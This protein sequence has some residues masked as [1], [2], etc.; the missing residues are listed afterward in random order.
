MT[1][2]SIG[3]RGARP[4]REGFYSVVRFCPDI[5]RGEAVNVGVIIGTPGLGMR[6]RMAE[7]NEYVRR[8]FGAEAFDN[9]RL[10]LVKN[11]LAHR[12]EEVAPTA[13]ALAAF[14]AAEAG[15]LQITTPR[16]M[17]VSDLDGEVLALVQRLVEDP[18][19]HADM[20][21]RT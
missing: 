9:T 21:G 11:G 6:V 8:R 5:D 15:K 17:V 19:I 7:R 12:L 1:A 20:V 13:E 3:D 4:D 16:P 18:E 10:T 14:G 2:D